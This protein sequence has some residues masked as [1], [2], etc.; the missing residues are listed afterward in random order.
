MLFLG[1]GLGLM[2]YLYEDNKDGKNFKEITFKKEVNN[3][4]E[5]ILSWSD[6]SKTQNEFYTVERSEDGQYFEVIDTIKV[7]GTAINYT[8]FDKKPRKIEAKIL[9]YKIKSWSP[10]DIW[11]EVGDMNMKWY[12]LAFALSL[13]SNYSRA[14]RWQT[15]IEPMGYK[16]NTFNTFLSVNIMY[17]SN[18]AI[19]RSGELSR[20]TV[21]YR[22]EK[23]PITKLFA[24]V[25]VERVIDTL[26]FGLMFGILVVMQFGMF[27]EYINRP[28]VKQTLEEKANL[29]P[30]L[31]II[32]VIGI[33]I[34]LAIIKFREKI[35]QT[36]I[37]KKIG[38]ILF[39]IWEGIKSTK[40][41]KRKWTFLFHTI[42]IWSMYLGVL[43][44]SFQSYESTSSV[45]AKVAFACLIMGSLGMI[46]PT[47][48]GI[49][50]W[51][52][53]ITITLVL[54]GVSE[55]SAFIY[56][57]TAFFMMTITNVI[58]GSLSFIYLPIYNRKSKLV[59]TENK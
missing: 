42:L 45:G 38:K 7:K 10:I 17:L 59:Q 9:Q 58:A 16:P 19:P 2:W 3:S 53:M 15:I 4:E 26:C 57:F 13:I 5:V 22:Y 55:P 1:I 30:I 50:T 52:L 23:I 31:V 34:L 35:L 40:D 33:L 36:S 28:D 18:T 44:V 24:T 37:G 6:T 29:W 49:G 47:A 14:V 11:K 46:V 48:G 39:D 56:S 41:I 43:V 27:R 32:G 51:N 8:H 12:I 21:L 25:L 54:Y 20:C